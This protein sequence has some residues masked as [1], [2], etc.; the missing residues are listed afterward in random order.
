MSPT[1]TIVFWLVYPVFYLGTGK[2]LYAFCASAVPLGP[3]VVFVWL[4]I[5]RKGLNKDKPCTRVLSH[6]VAST[7]YWIASHWLEFNRIYKRQA[8]S[9]YSLCSLGSLAPLIISNSTEIICYQVCY[10]EIIPLH[11]PHEVVHMLKLIFGVT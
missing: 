8:L 10:T 6:K 1:V 4:F 9:N 7:F 3:I 11:K 5:L 2:H